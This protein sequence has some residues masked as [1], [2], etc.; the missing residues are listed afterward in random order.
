MSNR[1]VEQRENVYW[2][3][4]TRVSLD[5]IVSAFLQGLSPETIATECF[6]ALTLEQIYGA[7]AYY[8]GN[9]SAIDAYL[10]QA[11][12]E[13]AA[14]RQATHDQDQPFYEKLMQARRSLLV[15]Q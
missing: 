7:I 1:Y 14:L 13:F 5:S 12:V 3:A 4:N 8:L 9:R 10:E 15:Q 11:E 2:I 6:P